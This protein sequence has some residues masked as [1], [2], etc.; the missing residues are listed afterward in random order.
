[1]DKWFTYTGGIWRFKFDS[2]AYFISREAAQQCC[3]FVEDDEDE[4]IDDHL[5][6]CYNC[7]YRRWRP[8]GFD[9]YK[10]DYAV[11]E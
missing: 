3:H 7:L 11:K 10:K 5:R 9:C 6:S 2:E 4:Q 8:N 1:M